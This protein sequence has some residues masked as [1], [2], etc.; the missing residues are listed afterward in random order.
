MPSNAEWICKVVERFTCNVANRLCTDFHACA[1]VFGGSVWFLMCC[2]KLWM[3]MEVDIL[4]NLSTMLTK[5][6]LPHRTKHSTG[7]D[8]KPDGEIGIHFEEPGVSEA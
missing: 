6:L 7:M 1:P 8:E 3:V 5:L 4:W 2:A